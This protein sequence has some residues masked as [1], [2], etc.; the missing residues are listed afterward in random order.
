M[1]RVIPVEQM[2]AVTRKNRVVLSIVLYGINST[3]EI[4]GGLVPN[5][6]T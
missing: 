6:P 2:G 3:L 1:F 5:P 4:L